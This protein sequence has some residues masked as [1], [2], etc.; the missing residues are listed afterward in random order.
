M[1]RDI[2]RTRADGNRGEMLPTKMQLPF[3]TIARSKNDP[4]HSAMA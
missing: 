3:W 2:G 4:G 1:E